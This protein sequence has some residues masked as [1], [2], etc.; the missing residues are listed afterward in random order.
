MSR[1]FRPLDDR[2]LDCLR[3]ALGSDGVISDE[4][5]LE[6]YCRDETEGLRFL[7]E[8]AA[9]P[10]SP[11]QVA[12]VLRLAGEHGVPVTPRGGGTGL[13]GGALAVQ[14]GIVLSLERLDRIREIDPRDMVAEVEAGVVIGRL[15]RE[16]EARGLFYP[17]D[18][19]SVD[20][21]QLGGNLAEDAAG[22][23]S[24][25]Y[26]TTRQWVLGLEVVLSDGSILRTG[27]R[28]RK[29][30]AGFSLTQLLVGSEGTLAVITAAILR[31]V[32]F[33]RA[34]LSLLLPFP[35]LEGAAAAVEE[36]CRT[37]E[38][39]AACEL[40]ERG[41]IEAVA[42]VMPVPP[43]L[44]EQKAVLLL[45]L[46]G[47]HQDELLEAAGEIATAAEALGAAETQ[48]AQDAADQRRL[49]AL[50]R[51]VGEA[52]MTGPAYR[53]ADAVVPRSRLADLVL[54]ARRVAAAHGLEV[55]CFGHA[56][57]GNLHI[58][59]LQGALAEE[60]WRP[61]R[62]AAQ[63]ELVDEVLALGGSI[64]GE[65]GVGWTLRHAF[66][67]TCPPENLALM[68]GMKSVFDPRGIL[69]PGKIFLEEAR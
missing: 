13:S 19:S 51:A 49:W 64:T 12:A 9:L 34:T 58:D 33:P 65:H 45:E 25:R 5:R 26:G 14:G 30:A 6:P 43:T 23:R 16:L 62:V 10:S 67:R 36:I 40:V 59:L 46:H 69:N 27:G 60:L 31:L 35:T 38:T 2:V 32:A 18:P 66:G 50:R 22:P 15:H 17:P 68:R 53:E 11:E 1:P 3:E 39:L 42:R 63:E 7:P 47:R 52:V 28:N 8:A 29:D 55:L 4:E 20:S 21:C 48:V 37:S 61:A 44:L 54:A 57:D 41:A 24:L 56:G